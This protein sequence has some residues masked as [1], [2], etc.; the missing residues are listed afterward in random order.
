L[1]NWDEIIELCH[2]T[3]AELGWHTWGHFDLTKMPDDVVRA[4]ITPP[5]YMKYFA[6]PYG[7]VDSRV[8]NLV[9]E[10]GYL[11]AWSVNQGNGMPL[12]QNRSYLG[13]K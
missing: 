10:A 7:A 3:G 11:E 12:Q 6:Y 1:C 4:E 9:R 2:F 5:F 8:E 13:S